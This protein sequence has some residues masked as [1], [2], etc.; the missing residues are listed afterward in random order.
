MEYFGCPYNDLVI[1]K[2][3][4]DCLGIEYNLAQS[5]CIAHSIYKFTTVDGFPL[6]FLHFR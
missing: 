3:S 6:Y 1:C 5:Y 2:D 4:I